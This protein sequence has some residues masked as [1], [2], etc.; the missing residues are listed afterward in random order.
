MRARKAALPDL[1]LM[2]ANT[3]QGSWERLLSRAHRARIDGICVEGHV[4]GDDQA[5]EIWGPES[6]GPYRVRFHCDSRGPWTSCSCD[7][8]IYRGYCKHQALI[9]EKNELLRRT[10]AAA[11][12]LAVL[13]GDDE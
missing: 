2:D 6:G 13:N 10:F 12:S 3:D 1:R 8:G 11:I 9:L 5:W 4:G 7:A